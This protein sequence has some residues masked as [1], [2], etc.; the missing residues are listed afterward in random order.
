MAV[1]ELI[2]IVP[3]PAQPI[4]AGTP[5]QWAAVEQKLGTRLPADFRAFIQHYGSGAFNDPGRL[6]ISIRNPFAPNFDQLARLD[7]ERLL[8]AKRA[9]GNEEF[10][11]EI[12]PS[13]PGLL[14]WGHDIDGWMLLW[15]TEGNP[16]RWPVLVCPPGPYDFERIDLLMTSF[17]AKAFAR[18]LTWTIWDPEFF[19]GPRKVKFAQRQ[20]DIEY[21]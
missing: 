15:L 6:I 11:F 21:K 4:D 2:A 16:D 1:E 19:S 13:S 17:L 7:R 18:E 20:E 8:N 3:P 14:Q 12:F 5:V 10:P 9:V